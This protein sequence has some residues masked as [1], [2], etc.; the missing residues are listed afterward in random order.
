MIATK[1]LA[2]EG[3]INDN[4]SIK[5]QHSIIINASVEQVWDILVDISH[6]TDWNNQVKNVEL[7]DSNLTVGS[8]FKWTIGRMKSSSEIQLLDK[9]N[10]LSWTGKSNFVKRIYVWSLE[11]DDDQ[12]IATVSTSLQGLFTV[13]V[14]NHRSVYNELLHWLESLKHKA[15]NG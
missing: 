5:D 12:T 2:K 1:S 9:P 13:W 6:W 4:A 10:T 15:E 11:K 3:K 14:E 8:Q 7:V